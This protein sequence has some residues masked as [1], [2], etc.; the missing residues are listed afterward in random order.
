MGLNRALVLSLYLPAIAAGLGTG[1]TTP[2][3]P[4]LAKSFD[5]SVG[6]ASLVFIVHMAG[7]TAST[8][9][10]GYLLDKIGRRKMLLAGPLVAAAA[11]FLIIF[12]DS[13]TELLIYRFIGGWGQQMW[14]LSRMTVIADT[15]GTY[16][17]GRQITSMF[18]AQR[19][20]TL[21]GPLIGGFVAIAWDIRVPFAL[22]GVVMLLAVIPSFYIIK[23]S[24]PNPRA[25]SSCKDDDSSD[26]LTWRSFFAKPI[27]AVLSAQ[28]MVNVTRGGIEGGGILFLYAVYA[29]NAGPGTLGVLS[30]AMA[31]A[32]IPISLA[33]GYFMDRRGRKF[34]VVPGCLGLGAAMAFM[35]AT[36][37]GS[38]PFGAFIGAFVGLHLTASVLSGSMQTIGTDIAPVQGRGMFFGISRTF[39][40]GGRVASPTSF[41]IM[42]ELASFGAAFALLSATAVA[43]GLILALM[44]RETLGMGARA[45]KPADTSASSTR[46]R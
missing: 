16:Q 37:Y 31:A 17:R 46:D 8:L 29:Y 28:F 26:R 12:A 19:V 30:S 33:A 38:L 34:T 32:G 22:H 42:S 15:A 11:S 27:P 6:V 14:M 18:S 20:G 3:L 13:F 23:E 43:G 21:A 5:V 9:P 40:M 36:A 44:V 41:A 39:S 1:I 25:A 7:S 2:V 4:I 45:V 24:M 35:A 10:T